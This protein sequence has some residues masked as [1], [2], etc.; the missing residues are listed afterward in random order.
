MLRALPC[1]TIVRVYEERRGWARIHP[2]QS[3]WVNAAYL[4]K[5]V[6][7]ALA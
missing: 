5:V 2:L 7:P 3:E 1:N 4:S 6:D